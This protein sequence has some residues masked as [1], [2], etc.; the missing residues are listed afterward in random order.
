MNVTDIFQSLI[1]SGRPLLSQV[2]TNL[3]F[4]L[5]FL[6]RFFLSYNFLTYFPLLVLVYVPYN[7]LFLF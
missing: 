3:E 1:F 2:L 7:I 4:W 5:H 6:P